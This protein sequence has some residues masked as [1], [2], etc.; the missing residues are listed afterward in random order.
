MPATEIPPGPTVPSPSSR[1]DGGDL[2]DA[3]RWESAYRQLHDAPNLIVKLQDDLSRSRQR[4]AFWISVFVHLVIVILMVNSA[5]FAGLIPRHA[6]VVV[7]PNDWT[8]QKDVTYLEMPRDAQK[9]TKRP[10]TNIISDK[11]RIAT[12]RTP[13]LDPK[14]LKQILDSARPGA[15][16]T[17]SPPAQQP[18]PPSPAGGP[19]GQAPQQQQA[20]Q[21]IP[22][23]P[24]DSNQV[25]RLQTPPMTQPKASFDTGGMSASS[26]IDQ[27]ARAAIANRGGSYGGDGDYG[28]NQGRQGTQALGQL[29]VLSDTMGVDFGPYLSRVL[30]DVRENWYRLIPDSA[31]AP[32]RKKGKVSIEFAILKDGKVAGMSL[33]STSGDVALDR[34]AWGGITASNPFPPLPNEFRGQYLALRFHF[35]Y[36]PDQN[37]LQ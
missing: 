33:V 13:H 32:L 28:L 20:Q 31:R 10:D 23:R 26:S 7:D 35:F 12:S 24:P 36:N 14:E 15:R 5:K 27:A 19:Q 3:R 6:V 18:A 37:E 9:V 8:K 1:V 21:S 4:E 29:D 30:H 22:Q 25:A 34:G 16:G 11:D 17:P 2:Y